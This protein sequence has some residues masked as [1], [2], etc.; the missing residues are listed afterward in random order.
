M[1]LIK[2]FTGYY[3]NMKTLII[4][5][6]F[7]AIA[8]PAASQIQLSDYIR[9]NVQEYQ[10]V[11]QKYLG[12]S[13]EMKTTAP[14]SVGEAIAR[15]P[16]RFHYILQN[17]SSFQNMYEKLYPDTARINQ[18]YTASLLADTLFMKY[19]N[20]LIAPFSEQPAAVTKFSQI[21]L[22][23]VASRFFYCD[24]VKKDA[25]ISSHICITLNGLQGITFTKDYT[26]LEAFAFEA[27]FENYY[28]PDKKRNL[29][30]TN[31]LTYIKEGEQKEKVLV[32]S[33]DA[34]LKKVRAYCFTKMEQDK[35]LKQVLLDYYIKN[36]DSFLFR[37]E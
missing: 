32:A 29:F 22:M 26:L 4:A 28:T 14:G 16:R 3:T 12:V 21:E 13:P 7:I 35:D 9:L 1:A 17:K 8:L 31:F 36:K 34:Y 24:A 5:L 33:P 25:T 6:F 2:R 37:I 11:G 27:I 30:I 23:Q 20:Q 18:L 10:E 19:F 15:F